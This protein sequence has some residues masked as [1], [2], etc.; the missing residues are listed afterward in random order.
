VISGDDPTAAALI[1]LGGVG[2]I[3]VTANVAPRAMHDL[4]EAA[5]AGNILRIREI[6]QMLSV[7]NKVLFVEG[8]PVPV[9][10]ALAEMGRI[11]H[12]IRLPLVELS[13]QH[14]AAIRDA[15]TKAGLL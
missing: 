14:H 2:N 15:L 5:L 3:S 9:K 1:L 10:W 8:N 7:L 6:D 11:Q 12:G 13:Q 4:C